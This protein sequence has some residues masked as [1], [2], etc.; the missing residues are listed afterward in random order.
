[1]EKGTEGF[2]LE[3][4]SVLF[5][6]WKRWYGEPSDRH[7]CKFNIKCSICKDENDSTPRLS[8]RSGRSRAAGRRR[9]PSSCTLE[10]IVIRS[11]RRS[12]RLASRTWQLCWQLTRKLMEG[13]VSYVPATRYHRSDL[14]PGAGI[15]PRFPRSFGHGKEEWHSQ[16]WSPPVATETPRVTALAA[17]HSSK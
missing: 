8:G 5:S 3:D 10:S 11:R 1:M 15:F 17:R 12:R 9:A 13:E 14:P 2:S 4:P 16:S 7:P 6:R